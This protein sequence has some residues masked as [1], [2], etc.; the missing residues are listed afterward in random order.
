MGEEAV[1]A[2][3][4]VSHVEVDAGIKASVNVAFLAN[5]LVLAFVHGEVLIGA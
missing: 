1:E 5:I 4:A 3:F 2:V